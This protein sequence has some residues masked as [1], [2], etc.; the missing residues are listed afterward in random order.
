MQLLPALAGVTRVL[1]LGAVDDRLRQAAGQAGVERYLGLVA[2]ARLASLRATAPEAACRY[3]PLT[4]RTA[5]AHDTDLLVLRPPLVPLLWRAADLQGTRYVAVPVGA[6]HSV[7]AG[8]A[9]AVGRG[10]RRLRLLGRYDL[11][12]E[13]VDAFEVL[14]RPAPGTRR[15]LSPVL[16]VSGLF[17]RLAEL[18]VQHAVLRWFED[19]PELA[20]GEDLDLLVA[21]ADLDRV[22]ALL[23]EEPGTVPVDVYSVTGL[24]GSDFRGMAYYPPDL[25][26]QLLSRAV[27]HPSGAKVPC[28]EDHLLSLAHHA[29]YHKGS[30]S[31]LPAHEGEPA[32]PDR[33]HDY[34]AVLQ[35]LAGRTGVTLPRTLSG[36]DAH[37]AERGWRPPGDALR[38]LAADDPWVATLAPAP[39]GGGEPPEPVVFLLRERAAEVLGTEELVRLLGRY[40]FETLRVQPLDAEA[41]RRCAA[42]LRGGN[43]GRGPFAVSGG[44]PVEALVCVHYGPR[45]LPQAEQVRYPRVTNADVLEAKRAVRALVEERIS[46]ELRFNALHSSDDAEDAWEYVET[47]LPGHA[48][49]LRAE[50]EERRRAYRTPSPVLQVLSTGRRAKVELVPGPDGPVVRKTFTPGSARHLG[51]ELEARVVLGDLPAVPPVLGAGETWF[52]SPYYDDL[53]RPYREQGRLLP[54][55]VVRQMVDVL[56]E[57]HE[58]GYD[59]LD[60]KPDNFLLDRHEG[61]KVV[62]FEFLHRY[63]GDPPPFPVSASF[64]GL[65]EAEAEGVDVPVTDR[66]HDFRWR[67]WT[68]L[69]LSSLLEEQEPRQRLRRGLYR[70]S[71]AV[72]HSPAR[73]ALARLRT[74]LADTRSLLAGSYSRLTAARSAPVLDRL[75]GGAR[76]GVHDDGGPR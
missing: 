12:D 7:E 68:G 72:R 27:V 19:L 33:D 24:P 65:S 75:T 52:T 11:G 61:L 74:P 14:R 26:R 4:V 31:G 32:F 3:H 6:R 40:G 71:P 47:A 62:D 25:A 49:D 23:A 18:G 63:E 1:E 38:R 13:R 2:P 16:G 28:P 60:A 73:R 42:R 35:E 57:V 34:D 58:R 76:A 51:R 5:L 56:R 39:A 54:L 67:R 15:Y 37:L 8:L 48:D 64:A 45:P 20:P 53:L 41:S 17:T 55:A 59:L 9:G 43:W 36:L 21:D 29:V 50:V 30:R 66:D 10:V 22:H 70:L 46:P 44:P 69:P